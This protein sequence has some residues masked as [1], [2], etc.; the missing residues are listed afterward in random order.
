MTDDVI[1]EDVRQ[2]VLHNIDSIAQWEGLLLLRAEPSAA[3][4]VDTIAR[5]LYISEEEVIKLLEQLQAR[6]FL[7]AEKR[8]TTH[9]Y[10]YQPKNQEL[11]E[12]VCRLAEL[13][14]RYLVPITHLIH[15][16]PKRSKIQ[17]FADAFRLRKD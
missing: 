14:A 11:D 9:F 1:P 3:W 17:K 16:K 6:G 7:A 10:R 5:R 2:F 4:G 12:M 13:Y 15:S 8:E